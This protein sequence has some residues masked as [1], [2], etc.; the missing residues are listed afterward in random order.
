VHLVTVGSAKFGKPV[1][2]NGFNVCTN[3]LYPITFK[4]SNAAGHGDYFD[5]LPP[6]CPAVDDLTHP[7]GDPRE[8]SLATALGYVAHGNC[9]ASAS[10]AAE[11]RREVRP[12]RPA[13]RYG[14]R[15]LVGGY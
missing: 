1:G 5:G 12:P 6:T 15:Q 13:A 10:A 9:G 8:S 2:E 11:A 4:I 7:L 3:V 14:W